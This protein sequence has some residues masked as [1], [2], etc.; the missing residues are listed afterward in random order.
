MSLSKKELPYPIIVKPLD[1]GRSKGVTFLRSYDAGREVTD[2]IA[3]IV[4]TVLRKLFITDAEMN[5]ELLPEGMEKSIPLKSLFAAVETAFH[6]FCRMQPTIFM[7][8]SR[9]CTPDMSCIRSFPGTCIGKIFFAEKARRPE[10]MKMPPASSGFCTSTLQVVR[11]QKR[12]C[13]TYQGIFRF[14]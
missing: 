2:W 12:I 8:I 4:Q 10:P 6:S 7:R 11:R 5:M 9:E 13:T 1:S 14:A 3:V